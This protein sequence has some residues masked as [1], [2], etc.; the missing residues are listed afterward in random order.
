ME[1][2]Q[3]N[4]VILRRKG[5]GLNKSGGR[6]QEC[7]KSGVLN[8]FWGLLN[9]FC[10]KFVGGVGEK[11]KWL[12]P[13]IHLQCRRPRFKVGK[14]PGEGNSHFII[15]AWRI[16]WTEESGGLQSM[17]LQRVGHDWATNIFT[18][19]TI[20]GFLAWAVRSAYNQDAKDWKRGIT[21]TQFSTPEGHILTI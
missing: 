20:P 8:I 4:T 10:E 11:R 7:E 14:I 18:F 21:G 13:A 9:T 12:I 19:M 17:G 3:N 5:N 1:T 15:L 6:W 16:P 2:N